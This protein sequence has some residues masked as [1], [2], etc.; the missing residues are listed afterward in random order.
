M[1]HPKVFSFCKKTK[2]VIKMYKEQA[3]NHNNSTDKS[4]PKLAF[5]KHKHLSQLT[6][7]RE[8]GKWIKQ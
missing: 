5:A 2:Q 3:T 1:E 6:G 8:F 7:T 4:F